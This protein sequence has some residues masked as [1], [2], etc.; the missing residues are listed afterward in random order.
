MSLAE[1]E[2]QCEL[3]QRLLMEMQYLEAE[4]VLAD[5]ESQAW[6]AQAW[7]LLSRLYL[8]LQETRRQRRQR[9]GEGTIWLDLLARSEDDALID[10]I[11]DDIETGQLLPAAWGSIGGAVQLRRMAEQQKRYL[12]VFLAAVYPVGNERVVVIVPTADEPAPAARPRSL[13]ELRQ[14]LPRD[15]L[16]LSP[17]ELPVGRRTGSAETYAC[18]MALW[19]RLHAPF[20]ARAEQEADLLRKM[21]LF[22]ET[23][24]VDYGCEFAHQ[25]LADVARQLRRESG[26]SA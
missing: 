12:D 3:G 16:I 20:L 17:E 18:T 19:E 11:V 2:E 7:D 1:I 10:R 25:H 13:D 4:R 23:I 21:Q 5:A 9:C 8:P 6:S 22:R 14:S 24:V 26:R 15:C